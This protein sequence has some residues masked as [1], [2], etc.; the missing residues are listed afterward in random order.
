MVSNG[1]RGEENLAPAA[2]KECD[3][4][5]YVAISLLSL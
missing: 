2:V 3:T 1:L 5:L 4:D